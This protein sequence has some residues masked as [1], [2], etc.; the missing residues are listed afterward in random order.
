MTSKPAS[1]R[2]RAT[3]LAPRSCPSSPGLATSTRILRVAAAVAAP[4][5]PGS[6]R[7]GGVLRLALKVRAQA[8]ARLRD[9]VAIARHE[10]PVEA[11]AVA[12]PSREQV[13]MEVRDGL[14]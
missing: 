5:A 2:A 4:L 1:R 9:G 13:Q 12:R 3:I 10:R 8:R 7:M 6:G 11:L 14:E